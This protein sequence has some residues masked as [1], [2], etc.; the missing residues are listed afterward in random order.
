[1]NI[2][3]QIGQVQEISDWAR[4]QGYF[5]VEDCAQSLGGEKNGKKAGSFGDLAV[6]STYSD[7]ALPTGEG[8]I[9][10]ANNQA[11]GKTVTY[12]RNQGRA[13]SGT[14]THDMWGMNFRITEMQAAIGS[15]LLD[16]YDDELARRRRLYK[17]YQEEA[18]SLGVRTMKVD[19]VDELIPFRF[20]ALV[21]DNEAA[22]SK[23]QRLGYQTRGFFVP[24]HMQP[25]FKT[26]DAYSL[27]NC[28]Q[29]SREGLCLPV[30]S[31][32][33]HRHVKEQ[34]SCLRTK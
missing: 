7:K 10:T 31:L 15:H 14:F 32:V 28:E 20:P 13:S 19:D 11:I 2:Y 30:H 1:M 22:A 8:G 17:L 9:L 4:E 6:F 23:L 34:I 25:I 33:K 16:S 12:F 18:A 24:M 3:G 5:V 27:P 29:I 26:N 21:S